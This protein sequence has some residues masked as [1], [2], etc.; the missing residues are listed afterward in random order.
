MLPE[1][2]AALVLQPL[3]REQ[4]QVVDAMLPHVAPALAD[5]LRVGRQAAVVEERRAPG[6]IVVDHAAAEIMRI[7]GIA[8]VGGA[9]GDDGLQRGRPARRD[10]QAVEAAPGDAD[11]ADIAA[12]PGLL[13]QP[14]DD[15]QRI[16]LLALH[17]LVFDQALGIAGAGN[18]DPRRGIA[19]GRE[20]HM[21]AVVAQPRS[22]AA[23]IGQVFEDAGDR[24][25]RGILR[26]EQARRQLSAA[27]DRNPGQLD[28]LDLVA[29]E[30]ALHAPAPDMIDR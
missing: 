21:L 2:I 17:I 28:I 9:G 25:L 22:V 18:V 30:L 11:H 26:Q 19:V 14:G 1:R 15:L 24:V 16:V 29:E 20:P 5:H 10:L 4:R 3:G 12:A 23:A 7:A 6:E 8:V 27:A 13:G